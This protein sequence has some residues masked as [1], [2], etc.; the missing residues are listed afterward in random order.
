MASTFRCALRTPHITPIRTSFVDTYQRKLTFLPVTFNLCLMAL[1]KIVSLCLI[2]V[3]TIFILI[4]CPLLHILIILNWRVVESS[5]YRLT[6]FWSRGAVR[7][8]MGDSSSRQPFNASDAW[9]TLV[10][11]VSEWGRRF[12]SCAFF[13]LYIT[14]V[15]LLIPL[16]QPCWYFERESSSPLLLSALLIRHLLLTLSF[17]R[18]LL[19]P[20]LIHL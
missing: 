10:G 12:V 18:P 13:L 2:W 17:L 6:I 9:R 19:P 8:F 7:T 16:F 15:L 1:S 3:S 11:F 20:R 14:R 5:F 4:S